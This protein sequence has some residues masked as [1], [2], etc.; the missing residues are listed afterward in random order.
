LPSVNTPDD[1][2]IHIKAECRL[3]AEEQIMK[4]VR[5]SIVQ[6]VKDRGR[7]RE[8]YRCMAGGGRPRGSPCAPQSHSLHIKKVSVR[9]V[10]VV[11]KE[12]NINIY[13]GSN[14]N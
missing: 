4:E 14:H 12:Y 1:Q 9:F 2:S 10:F 3:G 6:K 11:A 8:I 7:E 5:H 13:N